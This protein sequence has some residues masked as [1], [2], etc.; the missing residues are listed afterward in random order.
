MTSNLNHVGFN[1]TKKKLQ[2]VEVVRESLKYCLE[3]VDEHI[4]EEELDFKIEESKIISILQ[5]S[6]NSLTERNPLKSKNISFALPITL[7][8]FFEIPYE[9]SLSKEAIDEHTKWEYS[10]LYPTS[11]VDE[12]II[13]SHKLF[14]TNNQNRLLVVTV[15]QKTIKLFFDFAQQNSLTLKFIDVSS[16]ASDANLNILDKKKILSIYLDDTHYSVASYIENN[17]KT[18][19]TFEMETNFSF[20]NNIETFIDSENIA[21]DNVFIAGNDEVDELKIEL[22][23]KLKLVSEIFNPFE[24]IDTSESFIQNAHFL[25]T[26]NSFS[27]AAGVSF[28]KS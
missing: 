1:I 6:L 3:N 13:R 25:N 19:K 16:F 20:L 11:N 15:P 2:L 21:Y 17:L 5:S 28:R 7:F 23:T 8:N 10:V 18:F 27:A 22:E 24:N 14:D 26:P 4:F 12:Q 9:P